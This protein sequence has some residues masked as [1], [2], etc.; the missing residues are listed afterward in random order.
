M[1]FSHDRSNNQ[2][3]E[4]YIVNTEVCVMTVGAMHTD[5]TQ[6]LCMPSHNNNIVIHT[7]TH[8]LTLKQT[9]GQCLSSSSSATV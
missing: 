1:K 7:F 4:Q 9:I 3:G 5:Y 6:T 8:H 2:V